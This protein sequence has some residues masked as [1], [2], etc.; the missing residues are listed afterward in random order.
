MSGC[1]LSIPFSADPKLILS[2][3]KTAIQNQDGVLEGDENSGSFSV[4]VFG[5]SI[6]GSYSIEGNVM[7]I[8]VSDKPMFVPCSAIESF[9][10][11]KLS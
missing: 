6:K 7:N 1:N 11:S 10:R 5:N 9:L 4:S 2:K 8:T 3:V